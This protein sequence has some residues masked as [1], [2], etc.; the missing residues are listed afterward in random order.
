MEK[1]LRVISVYNRYLNRGGE[2]EVFELE[3]KLL[4]ERGCTV[5]LV[6][7]QVRNPHGLMESAKLA[8]DAIWSRSWHRRFEALLEE[9]RP[10]VVHVHN[11]F[12]IIS[13]SIYYACRDA[14]VP[15]VQSL[16][17]PRLLCPAATLY[18]GGRACEDCLGKTL[19]WPAVAHACYQDSRLRSG[20][21]AA[22]LAVH[23]ALGTWRELIDV[24]IVFTEFYRQKFIQGGLPSAKIV[25]K[26]HFV[27]PDPGMKS[28]RGDYALFLGRL[29][30]E[31]G[32]P[33]LLGAWSQLRGIPLKIRGSGPLLEQAQAF[34]AGDRCTVEVLPKR[35][36]HE[37]WVRLM[38]NARFLVWPTQGYYETFGLVA[39]EAFAFG[40]P[41]IASRTGAMVEIV[42]DGRTGLHFTAGDQ[43]DLAAKVE[44]AWTHPDE[45]ETMGRQARV[46]Y[47]AHYT[48]DRNYEMLM[49]IYRGAIEARQKSSSAVSGVGGISAAGAKEV[50]RLPPGRLPLPLERQQ[51]EG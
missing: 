49:D 36:S 28:G 32:V 13:P 51:P 46:E 35:L 17:N 25:V 16:H 41:V 18:R 12:P 38:G 45:M 22:M 39:I 1:T 37:E 26:S 5:T 11:V 4:E 3:A 29:S 27:H 2:D 19:A 10:D 7:E 43:D 47:E 8:A 21:I 34:A 20:V 14:E 15:V 50:G 40:V 33:T 48:A 30:P 42:E 24:F 6:S 23:G 44:W 9:K 31:K